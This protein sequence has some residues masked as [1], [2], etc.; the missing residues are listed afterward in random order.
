ML[1]GQWGY[2][3]DLS[4]LDSRYILGLYMLY[5]NILFS[6]ILFKIRIRIVR[7]T[8]N[9]IVSWLKVFFYCSNIEV[10][11]RLIIFMLE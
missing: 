9:I 4:G 11:R 10:C 7:F 6:W 5:L 1:C 8:L 2:S 3:G